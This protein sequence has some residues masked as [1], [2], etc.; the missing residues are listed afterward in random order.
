MTEPEIVEIRVHGVS[1]TPPEDLL[2]VP[3]VAQQAGDGKA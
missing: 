1:G 3:L 2:D